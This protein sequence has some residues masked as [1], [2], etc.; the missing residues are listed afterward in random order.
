MQRAV[1]YA[2]YSPGPNQ[3]EQSIEGQVREC[4]KYAEQHDLRIVGTYVDRKISGKTDNRREFQRMIDD[5]EK[6]IFD[7]IILYHTDRFARNR[8]DSAIYKHKLKENGV[9][10]RYATTDIPKGPEGIIL[11]SIMEG[12]AEYYSAELSRKIKRGMR[13]S[14][15]KCHSTGAGRC[16]G[17]RTAEDKSLVIEPEGAKAVQMVFDM[18]IKGKSHADICRYLNDCG[19]RTA[20]GKLFNKN[21]VTH[22]IRNKRYIGVY[23]YDDI[24]IEDGIP[25]IISKDTFHLAQLEAARRKTAK[26]PKEP[27]AEYLLSGKAFCGHCQKPLVGVSGT[28]KSG[29]KWYYYYCQ[30]SRAKRGCTKKPVKR[31]KLEREVVKRT[32]AEVL[33]PE[34]IQ[35]IAKK[36]Y[37]LQMEYRQDNS[38][39]LF[40]ELKLKDVRKAIKN[41]MHAIESGVKTKTLPARL[42]ELENEEEALEAELAIA[43]ASDFVITAKQIEF[44]LTQFAEPWECESEEE[45]H[46]RI[47]KCFVHK[48]FLFDDKLLIYYNVSRDGKTREQSE[49]ELLEEALGEGFDK[50]SSGSTIGNVCS[51]C[52][53]PVGTRPVLQAFCIIGALCRQLRVQK[54]RREEASAVEGETGRMFDAFLGCDPGANNRTTKESNMSIHSHV[55]LPYS[56]LK[57]FR[58]ET[59]A[60]KK[61]WYLDIS[62]GYIMQKEARKLGT[63]KGYYSECGEAFG[64]R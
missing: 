8:Y 30:E 40:Y 38:D 3:T 61:V 58:D 23:T 54:D 13:E 43:K 57:R 17:Y 53:R 47:I 46:R 7:V 20:R 26:R 44:L 11:E 24:T 31:D 6:H 50:R 25:A 4:T 52:D 42:Q 55:Q 56:I 37:D 14:A 59:T 2:R 5:S 51:C 9:E 64:I 12:W 41:T 36:C 34:V 28:G 32:V 35:H 45:Y 10:L 21:S 33:Q 18:Y 60:E 27:K 15:L 22:I 19:F 1:I 29:N 16:L 63:S 48:V 62:S 49:A 39:V